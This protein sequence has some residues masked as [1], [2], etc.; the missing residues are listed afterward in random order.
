VKSYC[1]RSLV[2]LAPLA[3]A[4]LVASAAHAE[5]AEADGAAQVSGV[6]V[7]A[8]RDE[9]YDAKRTSTATRTDTPLRDV[10]QSVSVITDAL[11]RDQSMQSM[12]DVVRY[13]P[14]VT[15]GQGEGHRDAPTLRGNSSTADFFVDGVRDDVQYLR[16]LYNAE[17]V[18]VLKG[19]NAMIFGRGGGGGVINRVTKKA[20]W[21]VEREASL[22]LGSYGHRRAIVDVSQPFTAAFAGRVV[23]MYEDSESF[24][25]FGRVERWG[26]NPTLGWRGQG[27]LTIVGGY[28]HFEDDR[29]VDRGIPSFQN[30][31]SAAPVETFFGAPDQ[32]YATTTVDLVNATV[33][34]E[35]PGGLVIRNRTIAGAYDKFYQNVFPGAVS[36]N[37]ATVSISGYSNVTERQN[38]F[39]QTDVV[40]KLQTGLLAHTLLAGLELGRQETDNFRRTAFF[41]PSGTATSLSVPFA[42]PTVRGAPAVF[43]Q[44]AADA[45]NHSV[46]KVAAVYIQD[47][48]EIGDHWQVVAGLRFD[49]FDLDFRNNRTGTNFSRRDELVS[50]R[51]G[52]IFKPAEPV[53][54]YASYSVSYL[55][56]SGDQF[57]SLDATTAAT[58][59]EEFTNYEV[60]LKWDLS[61][62]LSLSAAVYQLDRTNTRSPDPANPALI[63]LTGSQR[64]KGFEAG[65]AGKVT[66]AWEILGGYSWQEA[67]IT[68]RTTVPAGRRV[69]LTPEH[70]V[71][72]WNKYAVNQTVA[73]GLGVVHQ[74]EMFTSLNNT[75]V[76]PGFT[77]LDGAVFV[78]LNE[79]LRVQVNVQ[80]LTDE[81][82]F[83]TS[84]GDNNIMPGAPRSARVSLVANF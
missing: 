76:L 19:P 84:H 79:R 78:R 36:A 48:I 80:N 82:Y 68:S 23:G 3:L 51:L 70:T 62:T 31:P 60:G 16:D 33:E 53:S 47:Q 6:V 56:S 52:V 77:R 27:G 29:T 63:I 35:A 69:P 8:P 67:E 28:E 40:W 57:G 39:N 55:P 54:L 45:D 34:Y 21:S 58:E 30:R 12:A 14:G 50:P 22:E 26:V 59:P 2:A 20:D 65:I 64:S 49:S 11:I 5:G 72:L 41:G 81:R 4:S 18:E 83:P 24:R 32:S 74:S 71:S 7:T 9:A 13:V 61:P 75:V 42:D 43:R 66:D 17:R 10:P 38:L 73:L 1:S 37:G 25:E 15:M 44:N 46:A